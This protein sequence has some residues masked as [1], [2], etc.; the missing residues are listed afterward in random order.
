MN[1][2]KCK[3]CA[4]GVNH[5]CVLICG[6]CEDKD[7]EIERL[8]ANLDAAENAHLETMR[9]FNSSSGERL[10]KLE[11]QLADTKAD[12]CKDSYSY[13][14]MV[15]E[16]QKKL[17]AYVFKNYTAADVWSVDNRNNELEKENA[18]LKVE[19]QNLRIDFCAKSD[20]ARKYRSACSELVR[21]GDELL[22]E[23][24]ELK[25][26]IEQLKFSIEEAAREVERLKN[27][28]QDPAHALGA[29]HKLRCRYWSGGLCT[30]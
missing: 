28:Y 23:R 11:K 2:F 25:A 3:I 20:D 8:K 17:N 14:L 5:R 19:L 6:E 10:A 4:T 16:L 9:V 22:K 12:Y 13:G 24:D 18:E 27:P 26:E 1:L 15:G 7:K 29:A 21:Q 30:C